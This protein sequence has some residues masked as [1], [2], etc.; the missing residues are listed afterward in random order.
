MP[1]KENFRTGSKNNLRSSFRIRIQPVL[2]HVQG[3]HHLPL[4]RERHFPFTLMFFLKCGFPDAFFSCR[5]YKS[6]FGRVACDIPYTFFFKQ[7][8]IVTKSSCNQESV[9]VYIFRN[10]FVSLEKISCGLVAF[11]CN[12]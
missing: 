9:K 3:C 5:D 10:R 11:A 4:G 6:A 1:S 12:V 7:S 2:G 8:C